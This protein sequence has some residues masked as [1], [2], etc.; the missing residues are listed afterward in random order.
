MGARRAVV[1]AAS[2]PL[3]VAAGF[4]GLGTARAQG[5]SVLLVGSFNGVAGQYQTIQDAVDHAAPGDWI[6]VGPGDYREKGNPGA[7]AHL[8]GVLITTPGIT[9]RGMDRNQVVVDGTLAGAPAGPDG[10]GC[11]SAPSSQD[12]GPKG[13]GGTTL[14]RNGI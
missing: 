14:G 8:A 12:F 1:L 3:A 9:L 6:L 10:L 7:T 4:S 13:S 2:V 11:D 5:P